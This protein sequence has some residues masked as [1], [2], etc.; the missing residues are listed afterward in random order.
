METLIDKHMLWRGVKESD[1]DTVLLGEQ[2]TH[3]CSRKDV[4][5]L[6]Q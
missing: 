6:H 4:K 2:I 5:L 1:T 3:K